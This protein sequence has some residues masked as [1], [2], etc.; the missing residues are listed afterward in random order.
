MSRRP[1]APR[2]P[3]AD[4]PH[5]RREALRSVVSA[6]LVTGFEMFD[7][8]VFGFFAVMIGDQ[9][10]PAKDPMMSLLLAVGTFGVGFF[11]RPLGALAIGA[12]ADRVGRRAALART[13]W[14]TALG[15]AA[16]ALCP[17]FAAIGLAAPLIVLAARSLQGFALGGDIGVAASFVMEAGSVSQRGYRVGW[18][19]A[20]QGS[21]ALLGALLGL[22]LSRTLSPAALAAW[23]WRIP[24]VVGLLVAP[25]GL[26][27]RRRLREP[28][29]PPRTSGRTGTPLAE[30]RRRHATTICLGVLM[31]MGQGI[32]VYTIVYY[33]PS[34]VNRVM[35]MPAATGFLA[36]ACSALLLAALPPLCG[37]L[38][39]RL[40]R[41]KPLALV[42]SGCTA[43]LVYPV[44]VLIAHAHGV[45]PIVAGAVLISAAVAPGAGIVTLLVLEALPARVRASGLALTYALHVALFGST[46]QFVVTGL[47][48]WTG[49]PMA[50]AWY[51][52]PACAASF[53][54]T[55]LFRER[56]VEGRAAAPNRPDLP[57]PP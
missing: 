28:A 44:F 12:Y 9:F 15:T 18:Q 26:Y 40:P 42:S 5:D 24:F 48:K 46:A 45:L 53:C 29:L 1:A 50:A 41:R 36:S 2:T 43:L 51:V 16:L 35:H 38:A 37:R 56:R 3:P 32:P 27:V 17:P 8:T 52:A 34:Y 21:A 19:L 6:S 13:T 33:M 11:M 22:L 39:D 30:L 54:A 25:A 4:T 57:E 31:M 7:F 47:I 14:M 20:S 23:G 55:L 49:K 10:F